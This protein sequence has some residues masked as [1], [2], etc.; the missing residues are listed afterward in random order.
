MRSSLKIINGKVCVYDDEIEELQNYAKSKN[1]KIIWG[2]W[3]TAV[4]SGD[5]EV[6]M[7]LYICRDGIYAVMFKDV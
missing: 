3:E 1:G 2:S 4:T 6:S 5:K 7:V